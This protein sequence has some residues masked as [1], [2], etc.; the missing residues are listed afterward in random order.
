V[1]PGP[2]VGFKGPYF[3]GTGGEGEGGG[4]RKGKGKEG[5]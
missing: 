2:L 4:G 3:Y 5:R 1:L